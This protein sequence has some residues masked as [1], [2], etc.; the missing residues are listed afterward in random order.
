LKATRKRGTSFDKIT[1]KYGYS[2]VTIG[3]TT[4]KLR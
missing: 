2:A 3:D 1:A 4:A